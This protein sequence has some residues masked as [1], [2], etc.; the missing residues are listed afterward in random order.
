MPGGEYPCKDGWVLIA[1]G[2]D[3]H[4]HRVCAALDKPEWANDPRFT[5]RNERFKNR[6]EVNEAV[7]T[8]LAD[9]TQ[10]EALEHFTNHDVVIAPVNTIAQAAED[11]HPWERRALVEVDD[12]IAGKV[13]VSGDFWHFSRTPA[14]IGTTPTVGE[15]NDDILTT[16]ANLTEDQIQELRDSRV[17][18]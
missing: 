4:W 5:E 9:M 12:P 15:H 13:V 16:L 18:T 8:L 1:A 3:H 6:A 17:I 2:D 11:P 10:K 14:V 7:K